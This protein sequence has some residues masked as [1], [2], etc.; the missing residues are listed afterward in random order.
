MAKLGRVIIDDDSV[1]HSD[2]KTAKQFDKAFELD[3]NHANDIIVSARAKSVIHQCLADS[4]VRVQERLRRWEKLDK[5]WRMQSLSTQA[6]DFQVHMGG[7]FK[8]GEEYAIKMKSSVF[9]S[10]GILSAEVDDMENTEKAELA[11]ALVEEQ[12]KTE[13]KVVQNSLSHFRETAIYGTKFAKVVPK[14]EVQ[15]TITREVTSGDLPGGGTRYIFE[16]PEE[17][18]MATNRLNVL[19]VSVFDFRIP[20]TAD[21][22]EDA[23]WC[24]D[25][26]YPT[27][28][29]ILDLVERGDYN[30][31]AVA[32]II[33][34]VDVFEKESDANHIGNKGF[35][36]SAVFRSGLGKKGGAKPDKG[37]HISQYCRFEWWGDFDL[38]GDGEDIP[39]VI[40]LLLPAKGN[41]PWIGGPFKA[42]PVRITRNPYFHQRKP[43]IFHPVLKREGE[44]YS[45]SIL[46]MVGKHSY[47]EDELATLGLMSAYLEAAP[48]LEVGEASGV[49][50][51]DL[52]GFL[53]GKTVPVEQTGQLGYLS[54]PVRSTNSLQVAEFF[55][56]HGTDVAGLGRP[57]N[58]PR[59]AA[60]GILTEAQEIDQRLVAY[61]DSYENYWLIP[62][63]E[64]AHA[65]NRQFIT[66]ERKVK[67]LG[68]KGLRAEDIRTV[69]P[70]DVALEIRFEATVARK[71]VQKAF[72]NQQL[73]NWWD[74]A[75]SMNMMGM[76]TGQGEMFDLSEMAKRI[77]R[78][79][80]GITDTHNFIKTSGDPTE[81]RTVTEEH[82]LFAMGE[83]PEPE[84][85]EKT[86]LHLQ[87]HLQLLQSDETAGWHPADKRALVEH[88]Y[89]TLD[90][91]YREIEA[92]MPG[93]GEI[94]AAQLEQQMSALGL[95][96]GKGSKGYGA[97]DPVKEMV[98]Q[99]QQAMMQQQQAMQQQQGGGRGVAPPGQSPGSPLLRREDTGGVQSNSMAAAPNMGAQ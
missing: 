32:D 24:G 25:Y 89:A 78:D 1:E 15:R 77:F 3:T 79:G 63:A 13:A 94:I 52:D 61:V 81:R 49:D 27:K 51:A 2:L 68:L 45:P 86:W 64:L 84:P 90:Q 34:A 69:R 50:L 33:D 67:V 12:I 92:A 8:A 62:L 65:Y 95:E 74:R 88:V 29:E 91:F 71:L 31:S 59:T 43:Y 82:R 9:G 20:E 60:A 76:Q 72:Q 80:F 4:E 46:E 5:L 54:P 14:K 55:S 11:S 83:R 39:C 75:V 10:S 99:Q 97:K 37:P 48:P 16:K 70:T 30:A 19:P 36:A 87:G 53:P 7:P 26:S 18:E 58:A 17:K 73:I 44:V 6:E 40:T 41:R 23:G 28:Q 42:E 47:Y 66:A 98:M 57:S 22:I 93:T 85:G 96:S 38:K 56:R 21:G 35:D